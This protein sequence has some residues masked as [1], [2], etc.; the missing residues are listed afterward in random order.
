MQPGGP[1]Q[2]RTKWDDIAARTDR[3]CSLMGMI[4]GPIVNFVRSLHRRRMFQVGILYLGGAWALDSPRE[5]ESVPYPP[6]TYYGSL[7][8]FESSA[9]WVAAYVDDQLCG[10]TQGLSGLD[11][12]EFVYVLHVRSA[13][14]QPGCGLPGASVQIF[15]NGFWM[16]TMPWN[17]ER[18]WQVDLTQPKFI[19]LPLVVKP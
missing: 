10:E 2:R 15:V 16:A 14:E 6:T 18:L 5:V 1:R 19:F 12:G 13:M 7:S 8:E 4:T 11:I 9:L 3:S 17:N